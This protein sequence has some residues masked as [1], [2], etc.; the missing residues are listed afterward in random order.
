MTRARWADLVD[1]DSEPEAP[2]PAA[3]AMHAYFEGEGRR[4][5]GSSFD[6]CTG[7][8][9]LRPFRR[10]RP[11]ADKCVQTSNEQ[12]VPPNLNM[13]GLSACFFARSDLSQIAMRERQTE[14]DRVER[15]KN[16]KREKWTAMQGERDAGL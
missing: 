15:E 14:M 2:T 11:Y 12:I 10:P 13:A 6:G 9:W 8:V 7:V 1:S 3:R 16:W 4:Q 5:V